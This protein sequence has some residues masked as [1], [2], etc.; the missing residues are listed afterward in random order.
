MVIVEF[1]EAGR[2]E[3]HK[4][5]IKPAEEYEAFVRKAE[6]TSHGGG[7]MICPQKAL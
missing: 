6:S 3:Y 2:R 7:C 5:D 4:N 1:P